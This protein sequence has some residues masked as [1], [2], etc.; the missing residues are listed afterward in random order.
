MKKM[1][2]R[3]TSGKCQGECRDRVKEGEEER[4]KKLTSQSYSTPNPN[5]PTWTKDRN[6]PPGSMGGRV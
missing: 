2:S 4:Q 5:S 3:D 1:P 6:D